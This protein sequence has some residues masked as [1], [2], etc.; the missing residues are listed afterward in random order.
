MSVCP[1]TK[2]ARSLAKKTAAGPKLDAAKKHYKAASTAH[3]K[4]DD[5]TCV[6]ELNAAEA[7]L[8]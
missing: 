2:R 8:K 6:S 5:V 3:K 1:A 7:A 4:N